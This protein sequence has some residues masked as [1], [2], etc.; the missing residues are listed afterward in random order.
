MVELMATEIAISTLFGKVYFLL[1]DELK[2]RHLPFIS[3]KPGDPIPVS[4]KVV[5][6]SQEEVKLFTHVNVLAY[7]E[8][9]DPSAVV[10]MATMILLSKSSFRELS[11]GI[12]PGKTIGVALL[13]DGII[14]R[15]EKRRRAEEVIADISRFL[16]SFKAD[17]LVI[18]VGNG[19]TE[20]HRHIIKKIEDNLPRDVVLELVDEKG[21][22]RTP[23][24]RSR[25]ISLDEKPAIRIAEKRG[26]TLRS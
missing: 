7:T 14:L 10:D 19:S 16:R 5:L 15:T 9:A 11:I 17:K 6:T 24:N 13:G 8:R 21:T 1:V 25:P 2:R 4:I 23:K 26:K 3:L 20:Y 12:D 18:R 22:N